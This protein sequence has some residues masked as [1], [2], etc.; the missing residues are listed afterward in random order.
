VL[1]PLLEEIVNFLDLVSGPPA[2]MPLGGT[3]IPVQYDVN[4]L[5]AKVLAARI[6]S[7]EQY[8]QF[9][10]LKNSLAAVVKDSGK[11]VNAANLDA[12]FAAQFGYPALEE[13]KAYHALML[14]LDMAFEFLQ[15]LK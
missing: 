15:S 10:A 11:S 9:V 14:E 6:R 12:A 7:R 4:G 1:H 13:G 2:P 5:S 8:G 3:G